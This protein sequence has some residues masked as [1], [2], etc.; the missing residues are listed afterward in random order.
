MRVVRSRFHSKHGPAA[1]FVNGVFFAL[2]AGNRTDGAE[3][4]MDRAV[5]LL[6]QYADAKEIGETV[7]CGELRDPQT[8]LSCTA[9]EINNRLGTDFS[10]EEIVSVFDRLLFAPIVQDGVITVT[11]PSH[12]TD[13]EGMA[14]LSEEVIRIL[15]IRPAAFDFAVYADDRRK[16]QQKAVF[17]PHD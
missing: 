2:S 9:E 17:D 5:Q 1:E 11:I 10:C 8:V 4:A 3:K 7:Q 14:D 6:I 15:G 13:M 16:A 12:R